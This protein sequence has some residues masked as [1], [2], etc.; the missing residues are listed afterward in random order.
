M[1][2]LPLRGTREGVMSVA[3]GEGVTETGTWGL[4]GWVG[5]GL[6]R[7]KDRHTDRL[8]WDKKKKKN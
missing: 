3:E 2:Q 6:G 4:A 1:L 5:E 7:E 8:Y